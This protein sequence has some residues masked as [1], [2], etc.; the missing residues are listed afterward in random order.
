MAH[1]LEDIVCFEAGSGTSPAWLGS[2]TTLQNDWAALECEADR[3]VIQLDVQGDQVEIRGAFRVGMV[4]LPSG[5]RLL[6][7]SKI[8][9]IAILEWLAYLG[10]FPQLTAWLPEAGISIDDDWHQCI[11]RLFLTAMEIVTRRHLRRDYVP[12]RVSEPAIRGR[13]V[14]VAL[15][16]QFSDCQ[17]CHRSNANELSTRLSTESWHWRLIGC[18]SSWTMARLSSSRGSPSFVRNGRQFTATSTIRSLPRLRRNGRAHRA[19]RSHFK[20]HA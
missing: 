2:R 13:I 15:A 17:E 19:I 3:R 20:L 1:P 8:S 7:R 4:V 6:I 14:T 5:R 12:V 11:G 16:S 9:S 18:R 10:E